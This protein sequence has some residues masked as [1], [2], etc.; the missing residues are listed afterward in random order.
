M[1]Y[2]HKDAM[3]RTGLLHGVQESRRSYR[4]VH[5]SYNVRKSF[6]INLL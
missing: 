4:V 6:N 1:V 3:E 5:V 2:S